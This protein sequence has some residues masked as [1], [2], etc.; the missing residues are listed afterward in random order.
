MPDSDYSF[1]LYNIIM[2]A[3]YADSFRDKFVWQILVNFYALLI[4]ATFS[5]N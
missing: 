5:Y 1:W 2:I 4:V 3:V